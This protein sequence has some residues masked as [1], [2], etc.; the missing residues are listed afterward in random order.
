MSTDPQTTGSSPASGG[1]GKAAPKDVEPRYE[2]DELPEYLGVAPH[3]VVGALHG[4]ANKTFTIEQAQKL[5]GK[6]LNKPVEG[7]MAEPEP[8]DEDEED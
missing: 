5:I 2:R 4:E 1:G 8:V 7:E 6:W 3:V